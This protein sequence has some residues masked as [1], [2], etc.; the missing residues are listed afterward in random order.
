MTLHQITRLA[1][2]GLACALLLWIITNVNNGWIESN[3]P[4]DARID[5]VQDLDL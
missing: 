2:Y 5:Q 1:L 4:N 3:P